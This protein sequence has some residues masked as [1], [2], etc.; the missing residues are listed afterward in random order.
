VDRNTHSAAS[1]PQTHKEIRLE[2]GIDDVDRE[3]ERIQQ[4]VIGGDIGFVHFCSYYC[5]RVILAALS[6]R[7]SLRP[8]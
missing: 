1:A 3:L 4:Q 2:S 6:K 8:L 7:P 5:D